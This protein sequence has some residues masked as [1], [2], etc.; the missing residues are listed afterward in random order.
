MKIIVSFFK[1]IKAL[2]N[3]KTNNRTISI[4]T[5]RIDAASFFTADNELFHNFLLSLLVYIYIIS[6]YKPEV[7]KKYAEK[8]NSDY[9]CGVPHP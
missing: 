3:F 9:K 2:D 8:L 4:D 1:R 5:N 7:K 6:L